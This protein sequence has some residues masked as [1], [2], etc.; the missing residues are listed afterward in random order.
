M[1]ALWS[2]GL[3]SGDAAAGITGKCLVFH[4]AK[5]AAC[6]NFVPCW[7]CSYGAVEL[8]VILPKLVEVEPRLFHHSV[9][10]ITSNTGVLLS[11]LAG[12]NR[13]R[14]APVPTAHGF[15]ANLQVYLQHQTKG[16]QENVRGRSTKKPL[17][18]HKLQGLPWDLQAAPC[19]S[20]TL[21]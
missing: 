18:T 7:Y 14:T 10:R 6:T 1:M 20:P 3:T 12:I 2:E 15:S 19:S 21:L 5:V 8:G 11:A 16:I 9:T 17:S 4:A 13:R